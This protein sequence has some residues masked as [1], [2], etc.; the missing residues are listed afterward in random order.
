METGG[1]KPLDCDLYVLTIVMNKI[2][3]QGTC[4]IQI[5]M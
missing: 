4:F 3:L 2:R 5:G 1:K